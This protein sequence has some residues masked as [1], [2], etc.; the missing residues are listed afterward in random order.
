MSVIRIIILVTHP[1]PPPLGLRLSPAGQ[2]IMD[3]P[4]A[5]LAYSGNLKT[6]WL[7]LRYEVGVNL[8]Y[9]KIGENGSKGS[10]FRELSLMLCSPLNRKTMGISIHLRGITKWGRRDCVTA[11]GL[12]TDCART[13]SSSPRRRSPSVHWYGWSG[14]VSELS[15]EELAQSRDLVG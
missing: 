11:H 3:I 14:P 9:P 13:V 4:A 5:P 1:N 12:R 2:K 8:L 7:M 15:S 10:E 6:I